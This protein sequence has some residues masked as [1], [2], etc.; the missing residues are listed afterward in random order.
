MKKFLFIPVANKFDF[1]HKA[2]QSIKDLYSDVFIIDTSGKVNNEEL[3]QYD[4]S[5]ATILKD[6]G[7][8]IPFNMV[9]NMARAMA[10]SDGYDY[11]IFMHNDAELSDIRGINDFCDFIETLD[12][13]KW[14]TVF[15]NYD[16]LAAYNTKVMEKVGEWDMFLQQYYA[17]NDMYRRIRLAGY[18]TVNSDFTVLHHNDASN[19][20]KFDNKRKIVNYVTYPLMNRYY[21]VKWGGRAQEEK[22]VLPFNNELFKVG[23]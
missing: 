8:S 2:Y 9:Q 20:I 4:F 18:E 21:M 15:T 7:Y 10:I 22:N 19:T 11:Y 17:D 3:N 14:G 6:F 1:A 12:F 5:G 13:E 23:V 16:T